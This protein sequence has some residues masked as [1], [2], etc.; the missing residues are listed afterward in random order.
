MILN[1]RVDPRKIVGSY[2]ERLSVEQL[3]ALAGYVVALELYTPETVPVR[4]I[5]AI[6][7]TADECM[8]GLAG[9]GLDPRRFEYIMLKAPY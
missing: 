2:P 8:A 6:G 5:E 1:S 9:R 4:R 3:R 7:E